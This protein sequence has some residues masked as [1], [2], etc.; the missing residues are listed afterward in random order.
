M[1]QAGQKLDVP[2][3]FDRVRADERLAA[4][5]RRLISLGIAEDLAG[6]VD[7]T[8]LATVPQEARGACEI[9]PRVAGVTS[10]I[11]VVDWIIEAMQMDLEFRPTKQD[12][13]RFARGESLGSLQGR[14]IDLLT[15]ERLVLNIVSRLCG[16]ATLTARYVEQLRGTAAR[17]YDTRKT[18]T[19]WR[20][21]EKYAV[22]CGGG[23]NHRSGL[24]DAF[25]IKDNHLALGGTAGVPLSPASAIRRARAL[26]DQNQRPSGTEQSYVPQII[27]IEVDSLDQL[28][29]CLPESPDIVLVDNFPLEKLKEAVSLRNE[30][31]PQVQLEASGGVTIDTIAAIARTG[32]ERI[33]CGALTHQATWLDLGLDWRQ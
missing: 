2:L 12:G 5:T 24:Y 17:L 27:E 28:R 26:R 33:S 9:V 22:G 3:D 11:V 16:V 31:N 30:I 7:W 14:A 15:A 10:G 8:S 21:L 25:L 4:D 18:T 32:V 19:G 6:S 13:D 29:S 20:R 1:D 23:F